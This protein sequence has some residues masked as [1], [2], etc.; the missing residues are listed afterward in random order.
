MLSFILKFNKLQFLS[1]I[2]LRHENAP[3]LE[4]EWKEVIAVIAAAALA[5]A[6]FFIF[7]FVCLTR[8]T[9][10]ANPIIISKTVL[11]AKEDEMIMR[12][13]CSEM[14]S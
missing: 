9:N 12:R 8:A 10:H 5:A 7:T 14:Q 4:P 2:P 6:F 13:K 1:V 3:L 11:I